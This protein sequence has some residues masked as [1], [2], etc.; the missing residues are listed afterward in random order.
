MFLQVINEYLR[1]DLMGF[2][3]RMPIGSDRFLILYKLNILYPIINQ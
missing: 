2:I 1:R 3:A